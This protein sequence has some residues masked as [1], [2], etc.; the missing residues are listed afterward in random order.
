[1][2]VKPRG[3]GKLILSIRSSTISIRGSTIK[4]KLFL[5]K[6]AENCYAYEVPLSIFL[7]F[8]IVKILFFGVASLKF[9][10]IFDSGYEKG[11]PTQKKP[12]FV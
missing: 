5:I 11:C 9:R 8:L 10:L 3:Y 4:K 1:M 2:A 6:Q 12:V 7:Y